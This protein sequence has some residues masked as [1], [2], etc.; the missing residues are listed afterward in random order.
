MSIISR[1]PGR[2]RR[3]RRS[4]AA[5]AVALLAALAGLGPGPAAA[6]RRDPP[7]GHAV[8]LAGGAVWRVSLA[9]PGEPERL[10]EL[11]VAPSLV[12][13][14]AA[15]R[16]GSALL[17]DLGPNAAWIDLAGEAAAAPVYLPCRGGRL[18]PDGGRVLC[19]GR[20]GGAL[21][22]RLRPRAGVA[23]LAGLD[24]A[25]TALA[26]T[27]GDALV[28]ARDG[29]LWRVP[30]AEPDRGSQVAPHAPVDR[31]S[32]APGGE[33][34]VGRYQ[35]EDEPESDALF[36]FRLDGR[37]ARRKLVPGRPIGWSEDGAWLAV[38]SRHG[39]CVLRAVGGEYKCW[40]GHLALAL[41]ADG[42]HLLTAKPSDGGA[43]FDVHIAATGGV[44]PAPPRRL[45][46]GA[47]AATWLP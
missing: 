5:A 25:R 31:L 12:A 43:G 14:L 9:S 6:A 45:I 42:R 17:V 7:A 19:T 1:R 23:P 36:G 24:P 16:D 15:A 47:L 3:G 39:A 28:T 41:S 30:L 21:V 32:I 35:E 10:A 44:R 20:A 37:A 22:I 29:G 27:A 40:S 26:S 4:A 46:E 18:A 11:E 34:A 33:R 13:G 38:D 2:R 8:Y